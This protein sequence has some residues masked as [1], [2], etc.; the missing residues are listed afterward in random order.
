METGAKA[1]RMVSFSTT[2]FHGLTL[3]CLSVPLIYGGNVI[4]VCE[5]IT[6]RKGIPVWNFHVS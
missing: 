5:R 3:S 6:G 2:C 1:V 4:T